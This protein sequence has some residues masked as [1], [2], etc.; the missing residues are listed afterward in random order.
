[1]MRDPD[2]EDPSV[3][4]CAGPPLCLLRDDEAVAAMPC[5]WCKRITTHP[6]GSETVTGQAVPQ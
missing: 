4:V 5:P 2:D 6:D 3:I 1:M